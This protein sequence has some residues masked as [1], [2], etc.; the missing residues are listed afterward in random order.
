MLVLRDIGRH[1]DPVFSWG[2]D[3]FRL[4]L[5]EGFLLLDLNLQILVEA[6]AVGAATATAAVVRVQRRASGPPAPT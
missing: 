5:N 1:P 4:T 3:A 6:V 2:L